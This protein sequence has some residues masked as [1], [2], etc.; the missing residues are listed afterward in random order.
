MEVFTATNLLVE[1]FVSAALVGIEKTG[2]TEI[3]S[4]LGP[5]M[6]QAVLKII[7][8]EACRVREIHHQPTW[9][10]L[11]IMCVFM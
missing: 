11:E 2:E 1:T 7:Q 3:R 10:I 5:M 8:R 9:P 6:C 4:L